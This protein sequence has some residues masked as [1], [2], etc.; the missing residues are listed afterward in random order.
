M[1][2]VL[3]LDGKKRALEINTGVAVSTITT[4]YIGLLQNSVA[5]MDGM[6][7]ATLI[8][9]GQGNE[10]D[11]TGGFY[12]EGR[13]AITIG[14]IFADADGAV[15]HNDNVTPVEWL[16]ATGGDIYIP[17]FFITDASA[18][19]AGQ[20]L[21]VGEP[22]AGTATIGDTKKATISLNDLMLKVD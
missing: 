18:G 13:Q 6:D 12:G 7:L 21:W 9:V 22:D 5:D 8:S 4:L 20:V 10:F 19:A 15:C 1:G 17:A 2:L 3:G 14:T 16:N 11:G